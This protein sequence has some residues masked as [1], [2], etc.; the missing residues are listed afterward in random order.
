MNQVLVSLRSSLPLLKKRYPIAEMAIFGS[1]ARGDA[2][3]TS[4]VDIMV[5]FNAPVGIE[6][7]DLADE[8]EAILKKRVDLITKESLKLRQLEYLK[9]QMVY[10]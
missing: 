9:N 8:L 7:V 2:H 6:F 4:D 5:T 10:V 1:H 3:D